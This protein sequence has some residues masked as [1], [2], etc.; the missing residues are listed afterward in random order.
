M[1]IRKSKVSDKVRYE[2]KRIGSYSYMTVFYSDKIIREFKNPIKINP[3]I[4]KVE[5]ALNEG[6]LGLCEDKL[7][8]V[9]GT[10]QESLERDMYFDFVSAT[11]GV[12]K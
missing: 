7:N 1:A 5:S 6:F 11:D 9:S 2:T 12:T 8:G 3:T 10:T 4:A